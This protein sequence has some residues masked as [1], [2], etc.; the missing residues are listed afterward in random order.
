ML[1]AVPFGLAIGVSVGMLG[2][3]GAVLAV[4]VLVYVLG[5][6]VHAATTASLA[7]VAAA[8]LSGGAAQAS[9]RE[10]CW[11]QVAVFAPTAVIGAVVGTVGNRAVD[12]AALLIAFSL[13]MLAAAWFM[14]RKADQSQGQ[15]AESCPPLRVQR[16]AAAGVVVGT[17]TGFFGVGGGFLVVPL[18]ALAMRF[19]FRKAIGTSLVVIAF[20]S[21]IALLVHLWQGSELDTALTAALAGSCV[22]G[23]M[24]GSWL[25]ERV[26][27]RSLGHAFAGLVGCVAVV[28][29]V[30]SALLG[31]P[32]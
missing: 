22:V 31:G 1:A 26:D 5:E 3:G 16:A 29:L 23:A 10:V 6:D 32:P 12:G 24:A 2:G 15:G 19:P 18:L 17:M 21:I 7:V 27:A 14:W 28:V 11:P 4:P 20:V 25:G 30:E 9:R 8:A 13:V